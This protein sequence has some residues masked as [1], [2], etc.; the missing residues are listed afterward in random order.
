MPGERGESVANRSVY[1]AAL[2]LRL[3]EFAMRVAPFHR[4]CTLIGGTEGSLMKV[5]G[6]I[7]IASLALLAFDYHQSGGK[8][9]SSFLDMAKRVSAGVIT[10]F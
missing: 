7:F 10:R 2:A 8:R 6:T 1:E 4:F 3:P 5:F 9:A